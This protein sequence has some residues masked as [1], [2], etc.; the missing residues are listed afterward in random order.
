MDYNA[1]TIGLAL[2]A[3]VE[4]LVIIEMCRKS[5]KTT[6]LMRGYEGLF[7]EP[8]EEHKLNAQVAGL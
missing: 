2:L 4:L 7:P 6:T 5:R 8:V 1:V 3:F